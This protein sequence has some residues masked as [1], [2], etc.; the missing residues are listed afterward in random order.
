MAE[1]AGRFTWGQLKQIADALGLRDEDPE[2]DADMI[3][4]LLEASKI[5]KEESARWHDLQ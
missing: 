3:I 2:P 4:T 5:V 1:R